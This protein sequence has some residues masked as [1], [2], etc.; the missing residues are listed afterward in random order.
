MTDP[1]PSSDARARSRRGGSAP[2]SG[3]GPAAGTPGETGAAPLRVVAGRAEPLG[4]PDHPAR[5]SRPRARTLVVASGKGG[6]GKSNLC[7]NLAVALGQRGARVV[8]VDADFAQ[9]N[10][11]LLLG[12][13]PRFDLRHLFS[14]ER[15]LEEIAVAGPRGVRL[16]PGAPDVP[17]LAEL[18]DYRREVL[19]RALGT[20]ESGTDLVIMD[21]ASRVS[22]DVTALCLAADDVVVMTTPEM[23]AFAD[24]YGLVKLLHA[25]GLRHPPHLVVSQATTAEE[26]EETADRIRLVARRFLR[27]DLDSWGVIPEDPAIPGAVRRQEPVVAAF[28]QSPAAEAYRALAERL[29]PDPPAD[30][31]EESARNDRALTGTRGDR[32]RLGA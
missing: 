30:P 3:E 17:E 9:S 2:P 11:D 12:L 14:G 28:P 7:A 19:L 29:W 10:L 18:D 5:W 20:L 32:Q 4:A 31:E 24:A 8:L 16:V 21:T 23:P 22:R 25:Q 26:A 15:T 1:R 6:V 13:H 27:V